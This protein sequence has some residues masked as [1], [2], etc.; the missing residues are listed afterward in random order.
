MRESEVFYYVKEI[1]NTLLPEEYEKIPK[2]VIDL[3]EKRAEKPEII[4]IDVQKPLEEQNIDFKIIEVLDEVLKSIPKVNEVEILVSEA[5]RKNLNN[6]NESERTIASLK[7]KIK[8][9]EKTNAYLS[10]QIEMLN[11]QLNQVPKF[12]RNIF[13]KNNKKLLIDNKK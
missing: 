6:V 8:E 10:A 4:T 7:E 11:Q 1:L 2:S 3:L 13:I 12:I 5:E 9:I